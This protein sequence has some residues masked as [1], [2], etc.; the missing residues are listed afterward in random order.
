[1]AR[2]TRSRRARRPLRRRP[3]RRQPD[4][5][6]LD[7]E[8]AIDEQSVEHRHF[9][10]WVGTWDVFATS[11]KKVGENRIELVADT[12]DLERR[13]GA[14]NYDPLPVVRQAVAR[15]FQ[16]RDRDRQEWLYSPHI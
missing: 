10:F 11:G 8:G 5:G 4:P 6:R 3:L 2:A 7:G 15:A 1:M 12:V 9:D 16:K 14:R 13:Y